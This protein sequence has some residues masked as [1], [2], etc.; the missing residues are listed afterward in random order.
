MTIVFV[1]HDINE[2][3]NLAD[4]VAVLPSRLGAF[5]ELFSLELSRPRDPRDP[6]C[7]KLRDRVERLL[8]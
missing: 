3:L 6:A 7:L 1:T 8:A 2:A 4:R 5:R